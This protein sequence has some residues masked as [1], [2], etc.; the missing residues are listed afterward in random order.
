M[1]RIAND[2]GVELR[3]TITLAFSAQ[4]NLGGCEPYGRP[5]PGAELVF[6]T[7]PDGLVP[8]DHLDPGA[9]QAGDH[10]GVTGI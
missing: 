1:S 3:I 6:P 2:D 5:E 4:A 7:F 8:F 9:P 10:L